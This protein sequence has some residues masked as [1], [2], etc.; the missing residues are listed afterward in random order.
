ML[1]AANWRLIVTF[2]SVCVCVC[3]TQVWLILLVDFCLLVAPTLGCYFKMK[4]VGESARALNRIN[5]ITL[6]MNDE[7]SASNLLHTVQ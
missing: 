2:C 4:L 7:G 1:P 3:V 6:S 5:S